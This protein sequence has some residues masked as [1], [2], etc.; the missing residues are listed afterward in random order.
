MSLRP[1]W[2]IEGVPG[3]PGNPVLGKKKKGR[4]LGAGEMVSLTENKVE[5]PAPIQAAFKHL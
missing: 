3:Q 5:F 1:A 2:S 4:Q